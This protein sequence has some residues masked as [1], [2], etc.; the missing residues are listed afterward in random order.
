MTALE[1]AYQLDQNFGDYTDEAAAMLRKQDAVIKTLREALQQVHDLPEDSR[2][3][4]KVARRA[5]AAT[6][7]FK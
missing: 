4:Y 1:I 2:I 3:H 6:E 7:D 5:L